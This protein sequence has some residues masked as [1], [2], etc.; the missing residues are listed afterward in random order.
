MHAYSLIVFVELRILLALQS[1]RLL[2]TLLN[3]QANC[4]SPLASLLYS[5]AQLPAHS[6]PQRLYDTIR[7]DTINKNKHSVIQTD[8]PCIACH[9]LRVAHIQETLSSQKRQLGSCA[10][11]ICGTFRHDHMFLIVSTRFVVRLW[12]IVRLKQRPRDDAEV[13]R[14]AR[15]GRVVWNRFMRNAIAVEQRRLSVLQFQG[16]GGG[17]P[18]PGRRVS[19]QRV[20]APHPVAQRQPDIQ[21]SRRMPITTICVSLC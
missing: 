9:A 7:Y 6:A 10:L 14:T 12:L 15:D 2:L 5:A 1:E 13:Q 18:R 17:C 20:G 16:R 11:S 19:E 21:L 8:S 4:A 3:K